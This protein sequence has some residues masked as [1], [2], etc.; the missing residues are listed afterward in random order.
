MDLRLD[1]GRDGIPLAIPDEV[2]TILVEPSKGTALADPGFTIAAALAKPIATPPLL[3]LAH[4][5]RNA[6]VVISDKTRPVPN[7]LTLPPL[8]AT[9]EAAGIRRDRIEILVATGLHRPNDRGELIAM[10]GHEIVNQYRIRN[11]VAHDTAEHVHLGT[12]SR[13]TEIEIDRGF[14]EADLRI[15]TGLIEPHLMA[16]FSGGRKAVA[17]GLAGIATMHSAHG[18]AMLE[19]NI[20]PGIIDA[21]PFHEDLIEI[22]RKVGV[23]FLLDVT[24][25]R[26]RDLTAVFAGNIEAA[27]AVG[28]TEVERL[29][30]VDLDEAVDIVVTSAG[31]YPLDATFYQS[32]K[33]LAAALNIVRRGGTI[34]LATELSEGIGSPS[35]QEILASIAHPEEFMRRISTPGFFR[36]DQ[37]MAQHL[38]QVLRKA[39]VMVVSDSAVAAATHLVSPF[40][41]LD[42]ALAAARARH[43]RAAS[44]AVIPQGPYA[45]PTVRGRKLP[46]A[47]AW[48]ADGRFNGEIRYE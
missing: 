42:T 2:N 35:F 8:L 12:T 11:H 16:G 4:G 20:G 24:I 15:V 41:S 23:D 14:V 29:V 5:R 6:V 18:A 13:G 47:L 27:H 44:V 19:G 40:L 3:N 34:I 22:V 48:Q 17:P 28:M 30:R 36:I 31:G 38:C 7:H 25:D 37:W 10:T 39:D 9:L 46:L 32:I 1:Y 43:G 21:N 26:K 33:G 45:L